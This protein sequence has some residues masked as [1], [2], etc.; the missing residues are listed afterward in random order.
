[1]LI[2][3]GHLVVDPAHRDTY[4]A[5]C[6]PVV[7]AARVAPGCLDFSVT[8][9]TVDTAVVRIFERWETEASL[10]AFRGTGPEADQQIQVLAGDVRSY[11]VASVGEP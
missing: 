5:D 6:V 11:E 8:A 7:A 3:A 2:I 9:D 10:V 4:V 1:M